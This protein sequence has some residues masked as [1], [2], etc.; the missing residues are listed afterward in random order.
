MKG[1]ILICNSASEIKTSKPTDV[2]LE[3]MKVEDVLLGVLRPS[4]LDPYKL[5]VLNSQSSL[6][7]NLFDRYPSAPPCKSEPALHPSL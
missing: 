7:P 5:I 2:E 4:K 1:K 6:A 3:V